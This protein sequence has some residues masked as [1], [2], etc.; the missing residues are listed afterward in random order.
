MSRTVNVR[1][2]SF[3]PGAGWDSSG[4]PKQGKTNVRGVVTVTNYVK[5]GETLSLQDLGLVT[6]D[7]IE[8]RLVDPVRNNDSISQ[9][10]FVEYSA[11]A[12]QFYVF[13][14]RNDHNQFYLSGGVFTKIQGFREVPTASADDFSVSFDAFG[15]SALTNE[16]T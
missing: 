1:F 6:L 11:A 10:R 14:W 9:L 16:L 15:D 2:R 8:L 13:E 5:G 12:Q 4:N 7:D 3:L